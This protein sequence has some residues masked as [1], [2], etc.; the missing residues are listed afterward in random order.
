MAKNNDVFSIIPVP[1]AAADVVGAGQEVADLTAGQLGVFDYD[2]GLSI[3]AAGAAAVKNFF[4]A[5]ALDTT[6]DGL[7]D[8]IVKSAGTHIQKKNVAD[9]NLKCYAPG[10]E[11]VVDV[12]NFTADCD[13]QYGLKIEINKL[14][15]G[16]IMWI[17]VSID[18]TSRVFYQLNGI[19]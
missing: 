18:I 11:Q 7:V 4:V 5:L 13:K 6:G 3:D 14:A 19:F 12:V 16:Y 1:E 9:T 15:F 8:E 10:V 17:V 2:T